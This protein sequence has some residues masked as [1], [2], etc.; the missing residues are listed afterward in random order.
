ME[1]FGKI[2]KWFLVVMGV[3]ACA[4]ITIGAPLGIVIY[5]RE[6]RPTTDDDL[7]Y[8][9]DKYDGTHFQIANGTTETV[10]NAR[11]LCR[12]QGGEMAWFVVSIDTDVEVPEQ[13]PDQ[14]VDID[15]PFTAEWFVKTLEESNDTATL[16][17][18]LGNAWD[19]N[20]NATCKG[21]WGQPGFV[22][23]EG[24]VMWTD[25]LDNIEFVQEGTH[26]VRNPCFGCGWG[27]FYTDT[28][29]TVLEPNAGGRYI[30]LVDPEN[31]PPHAELFRL[32]YEITDDN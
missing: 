20:P 31:L 24:A 12:Y 25:L 10:G 29:Y 23:P 4:V 16:I 22:V 8:C 17:A 14:P 5:L 30:E 13:G 9:A 18:A 6:D 15:C 2:V 3:L 1:T 27:V 26:I 7:V 11:I 32:D 28:S 21:A 19:E